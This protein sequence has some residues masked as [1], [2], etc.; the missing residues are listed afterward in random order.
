MNDK[1]SI[2]QFLCQFPRQIEG[3]VY[4]Y[5]QSIAHEGVVHSSGYALA[6][7]LGIYRPTLFRILN[8]LQRQ[9]CISL[10]RD[11]D[12]DSASGS[13]LIIKLLLEPCK[14]HGENEENDTLQGEQATLQTDNVKLQEEQ[15]TLQTDNVTLQGEQVTLQGEE[16]TLQTENDTE[17]PEEMA[18]FDPPQPVLTL[19]GPYSGHGDEVDV[20]DCYA[21]QQQKKSKEENPPAPPQEEIKRKISHKRARMS[22][23]T[24]E[25]RKQAFIDS[26]MPFSSRYDTAMLHAFVNY[27]TEPNRSLSRMRFEMQK[28]WSTSLRLATWARNEASFGRR[29]QYTPRPSSTECVNQ[30]QQWAMEESMRVVQESACN[31]LLRQQFLN[32]L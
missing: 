21:T 19:R 5:L 22:K 25:M 13:K 4:L 2:R 32:S 17:N 24:L 20:T 1:E 6:K 16:V 15:A 26:I 31:R 3:L 27:W 11:R 30:A 23:Q 18:F 7:Q 8:H 10:T 29:S 28:T 14:T 9:Q 12:C